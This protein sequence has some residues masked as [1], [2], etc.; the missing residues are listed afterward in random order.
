M[1]NICISLFLNVI[2]L[3]IFRD[4]SLFRDVED[5]ANALRVVP[6]RSVVVPLPG[7]LGVG[8]TT[9]ASAWSG[10]LFCLDIMA[11]E[12]YRI[13]NSTGLSRLQ[14]AWLIVAAPDPGRPVSIVGR[15]SQTWVP[16]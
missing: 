15:R 16:E 6:G 14:E 7:R 4:Y 12:T 1:D 5:A 13:Y 11:T 2:T 8:V 10:P 9:R 3:L